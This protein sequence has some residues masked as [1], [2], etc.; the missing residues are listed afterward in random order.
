MC[1]GM[2][3][4]SFCIWIWEVEKLYIAILIQWSI[5]VM[6]L[7]GA[8]RKDTFG[9]ESILRD[10]QLWGCKDLV[11]FPLIANYPSESVKNFHKYL[12]FNNCVMRGTPYI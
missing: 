11:N 8:I 7:C 9:Y 12:Y 6:E 1:T 10:R 2:P 5:E 4:H 3:K